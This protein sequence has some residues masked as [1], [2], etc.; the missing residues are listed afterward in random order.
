M[1]DYKNNS[2][3][4]FASKYKCK[5]LMHYERHGKITDAIAKEKQ[6][7]RWHKDWK[8]NLVKMHNPELRDLSADW[9]NEKNELKMPELATEHLRGF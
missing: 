2:G 1:Q 4:Y 5:Y 9:F 6:W 3:G 7:K 8:W